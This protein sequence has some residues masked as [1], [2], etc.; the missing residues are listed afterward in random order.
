MRRLSL[1]VQVRRIYDPP[2]GD[3][4][5]RVLVDRMW[6]RGVSKSRASLDEWCV[7]VA[8]SVE[9]R[10]WYAHEPDR[11]REFCERYREELADERRA[12]AVRH[13]RDIAA[14]ARLT[15][16]TATTRLELSHAAVLAEEIREAVP[17]RS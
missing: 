10:R 1:E 7:A 4:G 12:A 13:L 6:P 3:D 15:L 5:V 11:H 16:L 14:R 9:L 17:G 8:P 2:A